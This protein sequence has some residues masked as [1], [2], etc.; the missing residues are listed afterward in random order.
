[1]ERESVKGEKD[2]YT[3]GWC[4]TCCVTYLDSYFDLCS[5]VFIRGFPIYAGIPLRPY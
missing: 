3:N 1:M 4:V 5:S 2:W